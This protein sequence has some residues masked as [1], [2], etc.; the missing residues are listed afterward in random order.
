ML[1]WPFRMHRRSADDFAA[2]IESH[3]D[4]EADLFMARGASPEAARRM[5]RRSFG[6]VTSVKERFFDSSPRAWLEHRLQDL[7]FILRDFRRRPGFPIAAVATM[8]LSIGLNTA[9]FTLLYSVTMRAF[10]LRDAER[11]V[12]VYQDRPRGPGEGRE[13]RGS[14]Y[15]VSYPEYV[16]YR[17]ASRSF[18]NGL[19]VYN[20]IDVTL[21]A[22]RPSS[23]RGTL[24]SCNYFSALQVRME[25]GRGFLPAEC[26][27]KNG[28]AV[29]VLAADYW[30]RQFGAD[31]SLVG[32]T[33][34][35]NGTAFTVV[36]IAEAGFV[37]VD[38]QRSDM[39]FPVT[40]QPVLAHNISGIFDKEM[41]S[42]LVAVGRLRSRVSREQAQ[43]EL[44]AVAAQE[45]A[46]HTKSRTT[47]FV[48]PGA[49]FNT[50]GNSVEGGR[51]VI[52][53]GITALALT[54]F[55]II[56]AS[57]NLTNLLLARA[58]SR[59]RE[60]ATRMALGACRS[61]LIGQLLTESAF[62]AVGGGLVGLIACVLVP[63]IVAARFPSVLKN[64]AVQVTPDWRVLGYSGA[65]A[66]L[67][68]LVFG[69]AP[70][71]HA[72]RL[73]I[74]S[75]MKPHDPQAG[76]RS[77]A[78]RLRDLVVGGQIAGSVFVLGLAGLFLR[79]L[80][81]ATKIDLGYRTHGIV[82]V[83][84]NATSVGYSA[85]RTKLLY[86]QLRERLTGFPGVESTALSDLLPLSGTNTTNVHA[87]G[88][89]D[90]QL[91]S[92]AFTHT[93]SGYFA[94]LRM[95]IVRGRA[96]VDAESSPYDVP[97]VV[98]EA[99]ARRLWSGRD[100]IGERFGGMGMATM[101]VT[102][103]VRD[104]H[105]SI[106]SDLPYF[107]PAIPAGDQRNSVIIVATRGDPSAL[108]AALPALVRAIDPV[109]DAR[110]TLLVDRL[111]IQLAPTRLIASLS[112]TFGLLAILLAT[113]GV[114]GIASQGAKERTREIGIRIAL[115]ADRRA[116]IMLV[117]H[118]SA[119]VIGGG[120]LAGMTLAGVG[121]VL[122]RRL[123]F[124]VG[125]LDPIAIGG[126]LLVV[127]STAGVAAYVPAGRAARV[128]PMESLRC[129]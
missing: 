125:P 114:F 23:V 45:D 105:N 118:R 28:E 121:S 97:A 24:A 81:R 78:S 40:M 29:V 2:E 123:L 33:L 58:I 14:W 35:L 39:W 102:G 15:N 62:V 90:S 20:A 54:A 129:D 47:M 79:G 25:R 111:R 37:G 86:D 110:S 122:V 12:S 59:R 117:A 103:V 1:R 6:N 99:M 44:A 71:L 80:D 11:V 17:D 26:A 61:R 52:A 109:V 70:A 48:V 107:Y 72:T 120:V 30:R 9:V 22:E 77:S 43:A 113:V 51:S 42:W 31:S 32:R 93:S 85:E 56:L 60:I 83:A 112:A 115:G 5:A 18:E 64:V 16:R 95:P 7:R 91:V 92:A 10:P 36:G 82:S 100:P 88:A 104:V 76:G 128:C 46:L 98:S 55:V 38:W 87:V 108:I 65:I 89:V 68:A 50:P 94:T 66:I 106:D 49:Y 4:A 124:G 21:N 74:A 73:D 34:T 57:I 101:R 63:R 126:M 75:S 53:L 3:L 19:A 13:V 84:V 8:A 69:L 96:F 127:L 119:M 27:V 67:S 41:A 116:V